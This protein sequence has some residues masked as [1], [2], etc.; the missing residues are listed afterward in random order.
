[1]AP[2]L[3][4]YIGRDRIRSKNVHPW[5]GAVIVT[6]KFAF[7]NDDG[8]VSRRRK[9]RQSPAGPVSAIRSVHVSPQCGVTVRYSTHRSVESTSRMIERRVSIPRCLSHS[10][11]KIDIRWPWT[12]SRNRALIL[13]FLSS[14]VRR[15]ARF[16]VSFDIWDSGRKTRPSDRS[17]RYD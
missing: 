11:A 2:V 3:V 15:R 13:R 9:T 16:V 14:T 7:A 4:V 8:F 5:A 6:R 10:S 1:M 12:I 17:R